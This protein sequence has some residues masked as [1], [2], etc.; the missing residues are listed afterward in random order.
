MAPPSGTGISLALEGQEIEKEHLPVCA[1]VG[2]HHGPTSKRRQV[3]L[4]GLN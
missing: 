1:G 2:I 3:S 4:L